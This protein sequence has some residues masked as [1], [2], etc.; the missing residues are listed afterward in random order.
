MAINGSAV[1]LID[2]F[3]AF[4]GIIGSTAT[5]VADILSS[6]ASESLDLFDT[7]VRLPAPKPYSPPK[8][9]EQAAEIRAC[10]G[11]SQRRLASVLN[12]THPTVKALEQ[13]RIVTRVRDLPARLSDIH[14]VVERVFLL[15]GRNPNETNRLLTSRANNRQLS[16]VDL[17]A[18]GRAAQAYLAVL[19]ILRPPD[20][21]MAVGIWPSKPGVATTSLEDVEPA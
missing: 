9:Q 14:R 12:T 4:R 8:V 16:A 11:W 3:L 21:G 17:L 1:S 20:E 5:A 10:T 13:G 19:D 18:E 2:P 6:H 7:W 15:A